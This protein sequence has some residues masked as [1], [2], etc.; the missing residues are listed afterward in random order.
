MSTPENPCADFLYAND[1][2][3]CRAA[4]PRNAPP[5][6]TPAATPRL[7]DYDIILVNY[8]AGKDSQANLD[9]VAGAA[10]KA[11]V[12]DRLVV[13]HADLGDAEW[14]GVPELAAE[15]AAHYGL[16]F[17]IARRGHDGQL[18]PSSIAYSSAACSPTPPA[19]GAPATTNRVRSEKS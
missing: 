16:R 3:D 6:V 7:T 19:A 1:E 2:P 9:V 18:R 5:T 17:E 8:S 13:A 12:L 10:R 14:D 15:H 11:G 4:E